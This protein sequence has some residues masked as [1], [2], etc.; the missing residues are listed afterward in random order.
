[1]SSLPPPPPPAWHPDPTGR[2][3]YRYWDGT[4]W[5][6]HVSDNGVAATDP[7]NAPG[8][9][10]TASGIATRA[11]DSLDDG[12][13][14]GNEGDP[15]K[16]Q[17]QLHG[18]S[19]WRSANVGAAA[20]DGSG[21]ILD[22]PILVVNQKAKLIELSNQFSVFDQHGQ[23][24]GAVN[25]TGQSTLK[26]A[27][28]LLTSYDQYLTH[29][30][31]VLDASGAVVLRLTRPAKLV[32]S[33]I[34][35][36]NGADQAIGTIRQDNVFGKIHFSL[37]AA[38]GVVGSIRAANSCRRCHQLPQGA[39]LGAFTYR[40]VPA[41]PKVPAI[42]KPFTF[43]GAKRRQQ[44][45]GRQQRPGLVPRPGGGK[46]QPPESRRD[47]RG[48]RGD[49]AANDLVLLTGGVHLLA[50]AVGHGAARLCQ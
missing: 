8:G 24:I 9:P 21:S 4:A 41:K 28:R 15:A 36:S 38:N 5:T 34:I 40:F 29:R 11:L 32:K 42:T 20:F 10:S 6:H 26:K 13:T 25:E 46:R 27:V 3:Q 39:L 19:K 14:V 49:P 35:V 17:Q 37:E 1:M 43:E 33:S 18:T 16:I 44:A 47:A 22:E 2:H 7:V 30:Y 12:L 31:E 50:A 45:E 23:R 48:A